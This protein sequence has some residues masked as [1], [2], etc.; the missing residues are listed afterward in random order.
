MERLD[1]SEKSTTKDRGDIAEKMAVEHLL[2]LGYMILDRNFHTRFGEIDIVALKDGVVRI[3]EVKSGVGFE[4]V[5]N[6]T[7]SKLNKIIKSTQLY[8]KAKS[9]SM[10]YA[11]DAIII[12]DNQI[13]IL[14]NITF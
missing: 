11:I 2:S 3:F 9:I 14:E 7:Q 4:P 1:L 8:L 6:L 13:E 10:P 12:K 5:F